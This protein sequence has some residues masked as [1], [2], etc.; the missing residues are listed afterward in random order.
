MNIRLQILHDLDLK[1]PIT[2][3]RYGNLHKVEINELYE[4]LQ[5]MKEEGL[6]HFYGQENESLTEM[7]LEKIVISREGKELLYSN[8]SNA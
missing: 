2:S 5:Q 3:K 4:I 6:I 1:F 8:Y 7:N